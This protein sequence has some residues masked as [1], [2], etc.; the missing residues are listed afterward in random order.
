MTSELKKRI[1]ANQTTPGA[2][3]LLSKFF[4]KPILYHNEIKEQIN[5]KH[6]HTK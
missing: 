4:Y 1:L 2:F 3:L 5:V 6:H